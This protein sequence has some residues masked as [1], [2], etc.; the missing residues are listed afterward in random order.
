MFR[1]I[2]NSGNIKLIGDKSNPRFTGHRISATMRMVGS[3]G[4]GTCP[5]DCP[6]LPIADGGN[7]SCYATQG[8]MRIWSQRSGYDASDADALRDFL[9][10]LPRRGIVR[11]HTSG[12]VFVDGKPDEAYITALT[13]GHA[14]NPELRGICY[15]HGWREL[16]PERF[17]VGKLGM[18][19]SVQSLA[20]AVEAR[21][22]GWSVA[23][24]AESTETR[25]S[26]QQDGLHFTLCPNVTTGIGCVDCKLCSLQNRD[27][28]IVFPAHGAL[29]KR[30][31]QLIGAGAALP[32]AS[33]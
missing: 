32:M 5:F 21:A 2:D 22:A 10:S 18:N 9:D 31:D 30:V 28:V 16:T 29:K 14:A 33:D 4:D 25:R 26:W 27:A 12:D 23:M 13:E 7:G 3:S 19:A 6:L 20:E 15:T 8:N 17:N 24:V 1:G 11:H